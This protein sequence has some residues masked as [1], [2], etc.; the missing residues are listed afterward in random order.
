MKSTNFYYS[1]DDLTYTTLPV[2]SFA[3]CSSF[4]HI[5]LFL[6]NRPISPDLLQVRPSLKR[7]LLG[8]VVAELLQAGCPS[9]H[10]TN[11]VKTLK[12]DNSFS[13]CKKAKLWQGGHKVGEKNS[14]SV[15]G[16]S[17]AINL[18][19]HRL[20][21]QKVNV[22]MT[23]IKGHDDPVYP[24]NSWF[25]QIFEWRTKILCLLQLFPEVAQNSR[26][27][28]R[29]PS[30]IPWEFRVFHVQQNPWVFHVFQVCGHPVWILQ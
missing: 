6:C 4:S 23:F 20:S 3:F 15:P 8:T 11:S 29:I 1:V 30:G 10:P 21:Q 7:K 19:F 28:V 5:H 16:F 12:D 18:L 13:T 14:V 27:S 22:I 9:C 24:V 2:S 17:R 26:N 25:T